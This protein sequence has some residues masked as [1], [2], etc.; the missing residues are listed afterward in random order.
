MS[1]KRRLVAGSLVLLV[2]G[3][4]TTDLVTASSLRSFLY[5]RLDEQI[6][7]AQDTAY[8]YIST[9][10]QRALAAGT[11]VAETDQSAWLA[12]LA[13]PQTGASTPPSSPPA[14]TGTRR[15]RLQP[16]ILAARLSPDIYVEVID[17]DG[18]LVFTDPSGSAGHPDPAPV[19]PTV[20]PVQ[21][22]PPSRQFGSL[23]GAYVPDRPA[24]E[25]AS[26]PRGT[27]YR[28]EAL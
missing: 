25:V 15:T 7:A 6:D 1:L 9:T 11:S 26:R 19:L 17:S 3:V 10:Y 27:T 28:A 24:F 8:T 14:S 23:H 5:G 18:R 20:L 22:Q 21:S 13:H 2:A 4:V 12:Q 16:A